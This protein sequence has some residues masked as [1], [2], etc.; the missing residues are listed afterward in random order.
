MLDRMFPSRLLS[1]LAVAVIAAAAAAADIKPAGSSTPLFRI[2]ASIPMKAAD[3][4]HSTQLT[5]DD[6][7]PL[8]VLRSVSNLQLARDDKSV[9]ITLTPADAKKFADITRKYNQ[10]LLLLEGD[11]RVLEAMHVTAPIVTGI[12]GFKHPEEGVVAEYLR[13]RFRIG[14]FK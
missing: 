7:H 6:K 11:G 1:L 3:S 9:L 10:G 5:F 8:L 14:E 13:R 4:A 2:F 12:I